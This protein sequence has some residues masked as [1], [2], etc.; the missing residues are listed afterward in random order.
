M[1]ELL[2]RENSKKDEAQKSQRADKR[3]KQLKSGVSPKEIVTD[4]MSV[5]SG[6]K[7]KDDVVNS[8]ITNQYSS[9]C[10]N[11]HGSIFYC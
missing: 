2:H 7:L 1:L 8:P 9:N 6:K 11:E 5:E 3:L 10:L 4:M